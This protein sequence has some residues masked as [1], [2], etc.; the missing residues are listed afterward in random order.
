MRKKHLLLTL[1]LLLA[2][3]LTACSSGT[4]SHTEEGYTEESFMNYADEKLEAEFSLTTDSAAPEEPQ[5]M[6]TET[7]TPEE[8]QSYSDKIIY[9]GHVY[10]E[11]TEFDQSIAALDAAVKE[12]GG[13]IQDSNVSGRSNG[14][15]TAVID[16]YAY[17]V[18]RIPA[19]SFDAFMSLTGQIGNVTSS[20]RSAENVTSRYTDYEARLKSLYTQEERLLELLGTSG[21]LESLIVLEQRLSEV[22]YEIESIERN[23]R[24]LDQRLAYSTVN[25]ELHEVAVYTKTAPVKRSFGEKISDSF[26]GGWRDLSV[27]AQNVVIGAVGAIPVL[28]LAAAGLIVIIVAVRKKRKKK[29]E[30][31]PKEEPKEE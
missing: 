14:E 11:T 23:L 21:D 2:L 4:K 22:R 30:E 26:A 10:V 29:H 18:I 9:S 25:I 7:I 1:I 6:D 17:Y 15:K 19:Q 31:A 13:F 12:Y 16:R 3:L 5:A 24:D 20:G 8:A 28:I 27:W